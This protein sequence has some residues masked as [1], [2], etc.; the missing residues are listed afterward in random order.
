MELEYN[1]QFAGTVAHRRPYNIFIYLFI[2]VTLLQG[3]MKSLNSF[4]K[5]P[6]CH[7]LFLKLLGTRF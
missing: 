7:S 3:H 1:F 5:I 2:C 4:K 6:V